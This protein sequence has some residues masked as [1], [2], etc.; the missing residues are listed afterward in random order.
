MDRESLSNQARD[1]HFSSKLAFFVDWAHFM[2]MTFRFEFLKFSEKE[3]C[4]KKSA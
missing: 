2:D 4:K 1:R 3:E